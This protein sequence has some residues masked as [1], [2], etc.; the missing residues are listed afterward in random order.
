MTQPIGLIGLGLLGSAIGRRLRSGGF[1]IVGS[2][3]RSAACD[4]F[5]QAGG[6]TRDTAEDVFHECDIVLLSLPTSEVVSALLDDAASSLRLGQLII[7]STTGAPDQMIRHADRLHQRQ[8]NYIEATVA[9]SSAE[10]EEGRATLFLGGEPNIIGRARTLFDTLSSH[11]VPLGP[12]GAASRFKLVHNLVLGLNRAVLAEGL[13]FA[14]ALGFDPKMTLETLQHTPARSHVMETKGPKMVSSDF[15]PQATLSQH[16]KDVRLILEEAA[17]HGT[18]TPLSARHAEL[19]AT[20]EEMGF[21]SEDN[22]GIIR[23]FS[24]RTVNPNE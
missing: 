7:D 17:A 24:R 14:A 8:V 15:T 19:L 20:V 9:G 22:S 13:T 4:R 2:D 12:V 1:R 23:A 6:E 18:P 3:L 21:G 11:C 16:L 10:L 5:Q